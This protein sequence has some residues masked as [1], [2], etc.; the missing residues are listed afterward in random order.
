MDKDMEIAEKEGVKRVRLV[1]SE[2][3]GRIGVEADLDDTPVRRVQL[4]RQL[5]MMADYLEKKWKG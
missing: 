4:I 2:G 1:Y 3:G 5:R